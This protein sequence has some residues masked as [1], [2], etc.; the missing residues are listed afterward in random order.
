M[1]D[2]LRFVSLTWKSITIADMAVSNY[3]TV[4]HFEL[5]I[6]G[7]AIASASRNTLVMIAEWRA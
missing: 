7:E 6:A 4:L 5:G 2:L 1:L 3:F